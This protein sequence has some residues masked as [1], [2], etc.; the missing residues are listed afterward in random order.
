MPASGPTVPTSADPAQVV[1]VVEPAHAGVASAA[2]AVRAVV[3]HEDVEPAR[4]VVAGEVAHQRCVCP[5]P[6][7]EDDRAVGRPGCGKVIAGQPCAVVRGD[8]PAL[9]RRGSHPGPALAPGRGRGGGDQVAVA[10]GL[11][12]DGRLP[13]DRRVDQGRR[14]PGRSRS[15]QARGGSQDAGRPGG[16]DRAPAGVPA[17]AARSCCTP[18]PGP[19]ARPG[20]PARRSPAESGVCTVTPLVGAAGQLPRSAAERAHR[21]ARVD[22]T[23]PGRGD[24]ALGR[25]GIPAQYRPVHSTSTWSPQRWPPRTCPSLTAFARTICG[26]TGQFP[27]NCPDTA[28]AILVT[29]AAAGMDLRNLATLAAEIQTRSAPMPRTTTARARCS[30]TG[31]CGWR[32]RSAAPGP[33]PRMHRGGHCGV[34]RAVRPRAAEDDRSMSSGITMRSKRRYASFENAS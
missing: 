14:E 11:V 21:Q 10:G 26:W 2:V 9:V 25:A 31:R 27:A 19:S 28:D 18:E 3:R 34:G 7:N 12:A 15:C 29:A 6:V 24:G 23:L 20:H 1:E 30:R 17:R 16:H 4:A 32:P 22:Q 13:D 8:G 33:H 5:V